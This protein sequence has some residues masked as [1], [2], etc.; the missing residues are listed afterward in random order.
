MASSHDFRIAEAPAVAHAHV[1]DILLRQ[2]FTVESPTPTSLRAVRGSKGLTVA[3]GAMAGRSLHMSF[4]VDIYQENDGS[5]LVRLHRNMGK[6][7]VKGGAIGAS[8]TNTAFEQTAN[9]IHQELSSAGVLLAS[10]SN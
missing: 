9:A 4:D 1:H 7:A 5:A 3:F 10:I 8:K 6:A 2:G